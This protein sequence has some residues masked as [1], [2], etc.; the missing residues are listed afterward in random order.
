MD[1]LSAEVAQRRMPRST[2][3][4][5]PHIAL[6]FRPFST[7]SSARRTRVSCHSSSWSSSCSA[8]AMHSAVE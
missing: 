2:E 4:T 7:S 3:S 5:Q 8:S 6:G 1:R